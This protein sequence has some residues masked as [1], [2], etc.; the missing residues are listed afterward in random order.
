LRRKKDGLTAR[1]PHQSVQSPEQCYGVAVSDCSRTTPLSDRLHRPH[2]RD[3]AIDE[4]GE[5]RGLVPETLESVR[6]FAGELS[7]TQSETP[8]GKC[9]VA[10]FDHQL[11][12]LNAFRIQHS[13]S[14]QKAF[15]CKLSL[16]ATFLFDRLP[17]PHRTQRHRRQQQES[18]SGATTLFAQSV[19]RQGDPAATHV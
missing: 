15:V 17:Q 5:R 13:I 4:D 19:C 16:H 18:H 7:A 2:R 3:R 11:D 14:A 8:S 1:R 6:K 12:T 9:E 10:H